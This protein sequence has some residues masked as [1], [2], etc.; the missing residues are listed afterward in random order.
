MIFGAH[1]NFLVNEV[2]AG[3]VTGDERRTERVIAQKGRV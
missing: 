2:S 3:V 1:G